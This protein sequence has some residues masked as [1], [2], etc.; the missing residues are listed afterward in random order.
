MGTFIHY[1]NTY[2]VYKDQN[3]RETPVI[4]NNSS[5]DYACFRVKAPAYAWKCFA[6]FNL[7]GWNIEL[8]EWLH[9]DC[10]GHCDYQA[11]TIRININCLWQLNWTQI[12]DLILHETAHAIV[13]SGH[14]HDEV[15]QKTAVEIGCNGKKFIMCTLKEIIDSDAFKTVY[16][17]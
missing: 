17:E 13:G 6:D 8:V 7:S 2:T 3:G 12:K 10:N 15:W 9:G 5:C 4:H 14:G 16:S 11:K 1:F